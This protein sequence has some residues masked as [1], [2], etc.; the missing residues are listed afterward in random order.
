[1]EDDREMRVISTVF[2][3]LVRVVCDSLLYPVYSA[4][5]PERPVGRVTSRGDATHFGEEDDKQ[6]VPPCALL[7]VR[8]L[9]IVSLLC[10][11]GFRATG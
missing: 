6:S 7:F 10:A 1:M 9:I 8:V 4:L 2:N 3:W 11:F 5:S